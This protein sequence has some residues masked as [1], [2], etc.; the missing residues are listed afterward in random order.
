MV[1]FLFISLC[2]AIYFVNKKPMKIKHDM[3]KIVGKRVIYSE[4][5][6]IYI[7]EIKVNKVLYHIYVPKEVH[8]NYKIND[9]VLKERTQLMKKV[10]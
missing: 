9:N 3:V 5:K 10:E 8:L 4:S 6:D 7:L 2:V 1:I